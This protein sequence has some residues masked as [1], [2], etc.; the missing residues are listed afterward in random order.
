VFIF[1]SQAVEEECFVLG[2]L[3]F[4]GEGSMILLKGQEA[5]TQ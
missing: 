4:E 5:L 1:S 2:C 3:T